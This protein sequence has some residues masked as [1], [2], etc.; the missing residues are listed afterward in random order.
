MMNINVSKLNASELSV[1]NKLSELIKDNLNIKILEAAEYCNVSSSMVSKLVR[2]L[3]F[4]NF[5]QYKQF[6]SGQDIMV[7]SKHSSELERLK[8][9]LQHFDLRL[10]DDFL[11]AFKKYNKIVLYGLGPS[12][13]CVEYFSYKLTLLVDKN[14]FVAQ[15]EFYVQRLLDEDTL[16]I[17]FSVTGKFT[18]FN[19][20]MNSARMSGAEML[21]ILEEYNPSLVS[22][23]DNIFFL[24]NT[25]QNNQLQ[26]YEKTR[27]IFFIFIE[28]VISRLLQERDQL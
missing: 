4:E 24:T 8:D 18:S 21:L 10:I 23:F 13:F 9:F 3:G 28:E 17:V 22:E 20:L 27:T 15:D 11:A 5:K 7:E 26:P 6:F 19:N 1:H 14:I 12:F 16:L 2:K 25:T